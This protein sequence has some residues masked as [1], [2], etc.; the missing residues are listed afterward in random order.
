MNTFGK[1]TLFWKKNGGAILWRVFRLVLLIG[2]CY[3]F[4][5][6]VLY[7]I[8]VAV[9]SPATVN[10]P[11]I[12]WIPREFS[13]GSIKTAV[14]ILEYPRAIVTTVL[15]AVGGTVGSLISCSLAGYGFARFRFREKNLM[16]AMVLLTIIVPPQTTIISSFINYRN[17]DFFGITRLLHLII[18][19]IPA[20]V[21]LVNTVWTFI[22]PAFF[23]SGLRAGLFIFIFRQFFAGMPRDL[24]EAAMI[25]GCGAFRTFVQVMLPLARSAFITVLLF[26]FVWHWND[27]FSATMYFNDNQPISVM[28]NQMQS[29][30]Q[31][32]KL[33]NFVTNTPDEIRTYL[34]A[35]CLLTILPP[36]ILYI[37]T[38]RFFTES[39]ERT[40]IVG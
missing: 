24:E 35:G 13:L 17:F 40:G 8:S 12:I 16:F 10:D 31:D 1:Q 23:A 28:L 2:I 36:L 14:E 26:S 15:I 29:L 20:T 38:Q 6:P 22:L 19:A 27:Y 18:P 32:A 5:F 11:S 25:D 7:M 21:K 39:I 34:Q 37:F 33:F 9:R 30:L 3:V 4:L